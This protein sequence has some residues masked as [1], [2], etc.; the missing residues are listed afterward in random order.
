MP[1]ATEGFSRGVRTS[2]IIILLSCLILLTSV[3]LCERARLSPV[4]PCSLELA[5]PCWRSDG[6]KSNSALAITLYGRPG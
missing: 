1:C 4:S 3:P 6:A 5:G 2:V